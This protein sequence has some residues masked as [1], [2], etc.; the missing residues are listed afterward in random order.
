MVR[1]PRRDE[2]MV[3]WVCALPVEPATAQE[4]LN[5]EHHDLKRN[6]ADNDENFY[7]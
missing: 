3:G 1:Q 2:Y 7:A 5:G 4:M 6:P